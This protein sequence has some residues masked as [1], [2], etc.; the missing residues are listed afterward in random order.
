MEGL[1]VRRVTAATHAL[2]AIKK[3][4]MADK[5]ISC[6]FFLDFFVKNHK[7]LQVHPLVYHLPSKC[8]LTENIELKN[9]EIS[10]FIFLKGMKNG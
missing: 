8:T 2:P 3:L 10:T 6:N 4:K 7:N 1:A 9:V 5:R